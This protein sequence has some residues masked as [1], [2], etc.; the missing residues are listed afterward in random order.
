MPPV[1]E[2]AKDGVVRIPKSV[3]ETKPA[4]AASSSDAGSSSTA[5]ADSAAPKVLAKVKRL[6]GTIEE[7]PIGL[8]PDNP[9]FKPRETT[10]GGKVVTN[11]KL[12]VLLKFYERKGKPL[13][14]EL[15]AKKKELAARAAE[16]AANKGTLKELMSGNK[17]AKGKGGKVIATGGSGGGG[18]GA[19]LAVPKASAEQSAWYKN[20]PK[21]GVKVLGGVEGVVTG[22]KRERDDEAAA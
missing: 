16:E 4:P 21:G 1:S 6:D 20:R 13:T 8:P 3:F 17:K 14:P 19:A 9:N 2:V 11:D 7:L 12:E 5:P 15:E 18:G 10:W 22:G